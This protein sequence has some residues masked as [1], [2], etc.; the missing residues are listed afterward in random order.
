[1]K[2]QTIIYFKHGL[3]NLIMMS[4]AIQMLANSDP[5]G[6]VDICL[7]SEWQDSRRPAYDDYFNKWDI[8]QD[9]INYP[10]VNFTKKYKLWF[11]TGHTEHSTALE[12]FRKNC[13]I[14]IAAP[15]WLNGIHEVWWYISLLKEFDVKSTIFPQYVP[16]TET[17]DIINSSK[18][19]KP[20]IGLCNGTFSGKMKPAKQWPYFKELNDLLK[21]YYP[22][23]TTIKV[24]YEDEL[25]DVK[26]DMNFV[27]KLSF[28]ESAAVLNKLDLFITTDTALMHVADALNVNTVALFGGSLI[29][30]NGMLSKNGVNIT[31]GLNCQ[32]CQKTHNF[33]YCEHYDCMSKLELGTVMNEVRR[34]L[35]GFN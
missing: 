15:D 6:K 18:S 17:K 35:N 29:S 11:Y 3:G 28:T 20:V 7:S 30:K 33:Y 8:I 9:V 14:Q 32:P 31:A 1:M 22:K 19:G 21:N 24:G 5:S 26:T 25:A 4:P 13:K 23:C 34:K 10:E 27:N 16:L 2:T 12:V